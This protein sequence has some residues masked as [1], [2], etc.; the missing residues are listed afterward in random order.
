MQLPERGEGMYRL[1]AS[2][3]YVGELKCGEPDGNGTVYDL[4]TRRAVYDGSFK[5]GVYSG[6]GK[7]YSGGKLIEEGDF[8]NGLLT[9]GIRHQPNG[10]LQCGTF[11]NGKLYGMGRQVFPNGFFVSGYFPAANN[12]VQA[13]L[14]AIPS[15][16]NAKNFVI[17]VE[18]LA[19]RNFFFDQGVFIVDRENLGYLFYYNGDVF[20]GEVSGTTP[21]NGVMYKFMGVEFMRMKVGSKDVVTEYKEPKMHVEHEYKYFE[22][23]WNVCWR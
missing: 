9:S 12:D 17:G 15:A 10:V 18:T 11:V 1:S 22:M 4:A 16:K 3:L 23:L 5:D 7:R 14:A 6:H 19:G 8:A 20:V 2:L 13:F 21:R